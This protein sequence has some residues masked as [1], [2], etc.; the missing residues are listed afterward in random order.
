MRKI[1]LERARPG[2]VIAK[3]ILGSSGRALLRAG[4]IIK[5]QYLCYLRNLEISHI[6]IR[7]SRTDD[8]ELADLISEETRL[9][10]R[11]LVKDIFGSHQ[12]PA[13]ANKGINI[14]NGKV[15]ETVKK[16]I[17]ELLENQDMLI[18]L[19]DMR[20]KNDYLFAHAVNCTVLAALVAVKMDFAPEELKSLAKGT[21]LHDL[22]M[23]FVPSLIVNRPKRLTEEELAIVRKHPL[24]GFEIF[25]QTP[26]YETVAG[27]VI[28]GHHER[29]MGQGYPQGLAG[30]EIE[31]PAQIAAIA[32]VYDALTSERPYRGAFQPHQAVEML[33]SFGEYF[34]LEILKRFLSLIAAYPVGLHVRLSNGES[35][36][37]V[38]NHPGLTLR[39]TVRILNVGEDLA[40]HPAPHD[41]DLSE[42]LDLTI[43]GVLD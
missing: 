1:T 28:L 9:E 38:A 42:S 26:V 29:F 11:S 23:V 10:A 8:V 5:P 14:D 6:Y 32:D 13:L 12:E 3:S 27:A 37:V 19:S 35:G 25:R 24:E 34:N 36:V 15:V 21:L 40:P 16:I 30:D 43:T 41:L 4:T 33:M 18:Q 39:P 17:D 20:A 7:D 31:I 22:G 2:M